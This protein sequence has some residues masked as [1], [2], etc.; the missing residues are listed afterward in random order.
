MMLQLYLQLLVLQLQ[1]VSL[2]LLCLCFMP[3]LCFLLTPSCLCCF[4]P[5]VQDASFPVLCAYMTV[6]KHS[7]KADLSSMAATG[8]YANRAPLSKLFEGALAGVK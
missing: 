6:Q 7:G 2:L 5:V 1:L 3:V 4:K 8:E